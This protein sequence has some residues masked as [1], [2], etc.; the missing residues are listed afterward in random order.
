MTRKVNIETVNGMSQSEFCAAFGD[1]FEHS[2]WIANRAFDQHPFASVAELHAVMVSVVDSS[3]NVEKLSLLRSHPELAGREAQAGALTSASTSEQ[4]SV[5]FNALSK[6]EIVEIARLNIEY[7]ARFGFP[8]IIAVRQSTKE[9]IFRNWNDRLTNSEDDEANTA[10][11]QVY[12][13]AQLRLEEM[14][15]TAEDAM[16]SASAGKL[17]THVLDTANGRPAAGVRIELFRIDNGEHRLL[18]TV[19][20]NKDGRTDEL[21]LAADTI[22]VG[23]Y[24]LV[25]HIGDYFSGLVSAKMQNTFLDQVPVR[26]TISDAN[27]KYHVPLVASPWSY[28]TYR[29]S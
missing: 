18:K 22:Q 3:S 7:Q 25:F 2:Q 17:S 21:L 8:F 29:G 20:T 28:S 16:S 11:K 10:L 13:I 14:L 27:A 4:A 1:I 24:Q 26:F 6:D 19:T 5:G 9:D 23:Q 15:N 12:I